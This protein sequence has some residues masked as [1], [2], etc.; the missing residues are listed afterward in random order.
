MISIPLLVTAPHACNYLDDALS[1][2]VF[3]EPEFPLNNAIY[4]KL[5]AKGFRRSGDH[6]Y[7]PHCPN[8]VACV[9]A[10]IPVN[11]FQANRSQ[12]RCWRKNQDITAVLKP[13][14]FEAAHY[15]MYLRYQ[16]SRHA[17][18][19]M[20][21]SSAA[22]YSEFLS[23]SWCDTLFIE[24]SIA[25]E[26]AALAVVDVL[27]QALSAV[28]TF[29]DPKFSE[30]GLGVYAVLWQIERAKQQKLD[31]VYLGYW[32]ETCRKMAY[33]INYQPLELL[34]N[35]QWQIYQP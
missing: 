15:Q 32:I 18:G 25:G 35:Q 16:N 3:V 19:D 2:T 33:K 24:F 10:R 12:Q 13:A 34:Q 22:E 17:G 9:P 28:Y 26:L 8:C 20:A 30:R 5:I 27:D 7:A 23:S 21:L 11:D 4:S 14:R 31:F 6:V 1:Q 29:F